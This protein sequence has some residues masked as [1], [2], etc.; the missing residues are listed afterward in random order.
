MTGAEVRRGERQKSRSHRQPEYSG[1]HYGSEESRSKEAG[2]KSHEKEV[3]G[4]HL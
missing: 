4:I 1:G 3:S 2:K